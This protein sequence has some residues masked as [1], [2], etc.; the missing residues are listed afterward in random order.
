MLLL[1]WFCYIGLM[2]DMNSQNNIC[3]IP[4]EAG[5]QQVIDPYTTKSHWIP[6][7]AGMTSKWDS[8][9]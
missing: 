3:F 9:G 2:L 7:F 4:A 6:A 1:L 5:I 8:N